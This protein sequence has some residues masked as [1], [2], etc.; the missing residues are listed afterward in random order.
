L[1]QK[2]RPI[3]KTSRN[4]LFTVLL[5]ACLVHGIAHA[6]AA[7]ESL[8]AGQIGTVAF[9]SVERTTTSTELSTGRI[10][11]KDTISGD[12]I[13]PEGVGPFPVM[14]IAHGSGGVNKRDYDWA[15]WF[16]ERGVGSF[17]VDSF[18]ERGI[19]NTVNDQ[20]QVTYAASAADNLVALKFLATH[21]KVDA[22]RIG[23]IGFSRGGQSALAT[24]FESWRRNI[25]S[26]NIK[27]AVH[28]PFYG[29]C[30]WVSDKWDGSP[31]HMVA[32]GADDYNQPVATCEAQSKLLDK[33]GVKHTLT[34]YEGARHGFDNS[35]SPEVIHMDRGQG[36]SRCSTILNV[37]AKVFY[38]PANSDRTR[39][40][41]DLTGVIA[42]CMT[43]GVTAG[44]NGDAAEKSRALV[45]QILA[46]TLLRK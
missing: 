13:L 40:V 4:R 9:K 43:L 17:I 19:K 15:R 10:F 20:S 42:S 3:I 38:S 16:K 45:G 14:V 1:F 28:I 46:D 8:A 7:V 33:A 44:F 21:P 39:P 24:A 41:S 29:G 34:V 11:Y 32:G 25:V 5:G 31:I 37:D 18:K 12:L 35:H 27:F 2:G 6:N 26:S 30:S 36:F 22:N 23:I